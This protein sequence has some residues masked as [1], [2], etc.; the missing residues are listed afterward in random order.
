V[1]ARVG[2]APLGPRDGREF[3]GAAAASRRL[4]RPWVAPPLTLADYEAKLERLRPPAHHGFAIRRNDT[5]ALVGC[6]EITNIVRGAFLSAYL[7]YYAF[8][9]H[10]R[11]GLMT[12]GIGLVARHAFGPLGLHRLEANIQPGNV[13]SL[14]LARACGFAREGFSPRYLKIGGRWRDHE[15][16]ALLAR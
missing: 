7:S 16:W 11:Q 6:A 8:A 5:G 9:G 3:V 1:K 15:R 2:I 4:H 12:Q 14:A 10:E 13:A